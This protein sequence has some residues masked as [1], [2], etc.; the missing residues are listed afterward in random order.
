MPP[1]RVRNGIEAA[2]LAEGRTALDAQ[3]GQR[4]QQKK[5]ASHSVLLS[6]GNRRRNA[7]ANQLAGGRGGR[8]RRSRA[9]VGGERCEGRDS[10]E[11]TRRGGVQRNGT[12]AIAATQHVPQ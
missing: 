10:S 6:G 11:L 9:T 7:A 3:R 12:K 2:V 5:C 8:S 4:H 1:C